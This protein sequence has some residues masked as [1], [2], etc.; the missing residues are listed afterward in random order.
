MLTEGDKAPKLTVTACEGR[1][2]DIGAPGRRTVL[3]FFGKAG[4][5]G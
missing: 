1:P 2:F 3:W 4:T 5:S